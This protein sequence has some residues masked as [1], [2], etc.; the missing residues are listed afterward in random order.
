[1][2]PKAFSYEEKS[3]VSTTGTTF[4]IYIKS[5][6]IYVVIVVSSECARIRNFCCLVAARLESIVN[7]GLFA[8]TT[9]GN[10]YGVETTDLLPHEMRFKCEKKL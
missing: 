6:F 9:G 3:T 4:S 8:A 10:N 2:P 5:V 7:A 1:L